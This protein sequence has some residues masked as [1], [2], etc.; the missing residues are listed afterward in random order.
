VTILRALGLAAALW[1]LLLALPSA[2]AV[3]PEAPQPGAGRPPKLLGREQ[4]GR[5]FRKPGTLLHQ[6]RRN[7]PQVDLK[8]LRRRKIE[9]VARRAHHTDRL[10]PINSPA[11][12][13]EAPLMAPGE[14]TPEADDAQ[15]NPP[16]LRAWHVLV[17]VGVTVAVVIVVLRLTGRQRCQEP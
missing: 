11:G 12:T 10:A 1:A 17:F 3:Q 13:I 5:T 15:E 16:G 8:A 4:N 7:S 2:M 6:A 14:E 9:Q